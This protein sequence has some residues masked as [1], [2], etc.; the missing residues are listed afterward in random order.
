MLVALILR[1]V[2]VALAWRSIIDPDNHFGNFAAEM[3]WV[4]RSLVTG[5]G[6][7]S[8]FFPTTGPTALVPPLFPFLLAGVFRVFG[9]YS[10]H[11]AIAILALDSL[12]STLTCIPVY[13][14]LRHTAGLR[15]ARLGAWLWALYPFAINYASSEVWD[16]ALT[17]LL[18]A[19]C[20]YLAL[21]L[22]QRHTLWAWFA[23]GLLYG[24]T[25]L[26]NPSVLSLFPFLLLPA[27]W[28][29]PRSP[30]SRLAGIAIAIL[31]L[32]LVLT[33]WN[34]RNHRVFH[35]NIPVR[36]GFWLEFYAGNHGDSWTSNPPNTHPATSAAEMDRFVALGEMRY[37]ADKEQI[38]KSFVR[39]HPVWFLTACLRRFIRFWTGVW[40]LSPAYIRYQPLDV[41]N[42][43]FCTAVT[44]LMLRGLAR[45]LRHNAAHAL[46]FLITI[47]LFPIPYYLT[48]ASMDYRQPIEPIILMLATI[49]IIGF[50]EKY[51]TAN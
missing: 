44:L 4:A 11:S 43:F 42:L 30:H 32:L 7:S 14:A 25:A 31:G 48:H 21:R 23:F 37:I 29:I 28:S 51:P 19:I 9:L 22:G 40:S 47:L 46:P 12:F 41:P 45:W 6:F 38:A 26:S 16:Y 33:P 27:L 2:V 17:S 15:P 39:S 13:L 20:F 3:G 1:L 50:A 35:Q 49:G 18:F 10:A 24:L 34:I 8:P 36:N 5:H